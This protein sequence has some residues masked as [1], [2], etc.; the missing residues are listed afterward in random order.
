MKNY[1]DE[2]RGMGNEDGIRGRGTE[3]GNGDGEQE[4]VITGKEMT[5]AVKGD[6]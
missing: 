6:G 5:A 3:M 2:E 4:R 1:R